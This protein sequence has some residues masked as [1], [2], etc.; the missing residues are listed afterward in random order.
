MDRSPHKILRL[1]QEKKNG[2]N[3]WFSEDEKYILN[4]NL[5][6][7]N[8]IVKIVLFNAKP[9]YLFKLLTSFYCQYWKHPHGSSTDH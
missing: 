8:K 9:K 3:N 5:D 2:I 1:L 6:L 7:K 4:E